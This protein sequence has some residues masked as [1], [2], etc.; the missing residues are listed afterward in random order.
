MIS[1]QKTKKQK[2]KIT[3]IYSKKSFL[4]KII[5]SSLKKKKHEAPTKKKKKS[6]KFILKNHFLEKL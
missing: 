3:Q 4:G 6:P 5:I 1:N 2:K